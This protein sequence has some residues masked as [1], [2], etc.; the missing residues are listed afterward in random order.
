MGRPPVQLLVNSSQNFLV[1]SLSYYEKKNS[2]LHVT[3][4]DENEM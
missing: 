4:L 3:S 1:F 2:F